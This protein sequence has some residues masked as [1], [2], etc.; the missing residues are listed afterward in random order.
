[1][2]TTNIYAK[3]GGEGRTYQTLKNAESSG[4]S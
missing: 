3:Q 1:M 4:P 2:M